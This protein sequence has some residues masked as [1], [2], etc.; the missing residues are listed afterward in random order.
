MP[1]KLGGLG[2]I[3]P[4]ELSDVSYQNSR[5][6]TTELVKKIVLQNETIV[7]S[8]EEE[9]AEVIQQIQKNKATR[10]AEKFTYV[11]G[12]LDTHKLKLLEATTEKGASSWLTT[13][14]LRNHD[15]YLNKQ[16]FWDAV[17]M[18]YGIPL[19]RLPS[20]CVCKKSFTVEHAMSCQRGGFIHIRHNELRDF[21]AELLSEVC[22]DVSI[23]P[24]LTPLTGER[25]SYNTANVEDHARLD[26][27]ARGVWNRGSRAYCDVRVFNPLAPTYQ[28][29]TLK[30]AH[31]S[32]ENAKKR[33]YGE[34]VRNVEHGTFTPLV[35]TCFGGM[36]VECA[37]FYDKLSEMLSEKRDTPLSIV[38]SW[39]RTKISFSLLRTMNLCIRGSRTKTQ[40]SEDL[41]ST[42]I[43]MAVMDTR[44]ENQP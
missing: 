17:Y 16:E 15:L 14:P 1:A 25:F 29:Q 32:N 28:D 43:I 37:R 2:L 36:S 34:R 11:K 40:H 6:A 31:K 30:A 35:F 26:V 39:I 5:F 38:K 18:R 20:T 33:E 21:T 7:E 19:P 41:A 22:K 13:M 27:A 3:I 42:N 4:S 10:D 24:M 44:T 12:T 23:E 8:V 9:R